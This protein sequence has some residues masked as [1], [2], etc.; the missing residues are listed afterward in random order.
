VIVYGN[1]ATADRA[2]FR[3]VLS[4]HRSTAE[5]A[6]RPAEGIDG[7]ELYL[8]SDDLNAKLTEN[9]IDDSSSYSM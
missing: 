8:M 2:F 5:M 6:A 1:D 7:H 3:D 9:S 4:A